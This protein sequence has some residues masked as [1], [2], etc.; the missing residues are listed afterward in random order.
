MDNN[1]LDTNNSD[2]EKL[3]LHIRNKEKRVYTDEELIHLPDINKTH[4]HSG[5]WRIRKI[6]S[7]RLTAY[8]KKKNK[9]L[10][11]LEVGCGNGW[12]SAKLAEIQNTDVIGLD[13]NSTELSQAKRVLKKN[14]LEFVF[15][16]IDEQALENTKFDII[17]FAASIQY[18]SSFQDVI[19]LSLSMLRPGGEIHLV[20][21]SFYSADEVNSAAKRTHNYYQ[22]LQCPEMAAWYFHHQFDKLQ[23]FKFKILAN[24]YSLL[25]RF[26]YKTPFYW[27]AI[28]H[29]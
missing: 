6:T 21:T 22:L 27:I 24:P 18:F 29:Q 9:P 8:L 20:D 4:I 2:F 5:E 11:I 7:G 12:L 10:S 3:Y 14:N 26:Y 15:R 1:S 17:V 23:P 28:T 13:I 25:N 16:T 19:D